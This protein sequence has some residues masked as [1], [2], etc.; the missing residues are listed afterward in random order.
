ME[1]DEIENSIR[2]QKRQINKNK[3]RENILW[4]KRYYE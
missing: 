4:R 2:E 1:F 3:N